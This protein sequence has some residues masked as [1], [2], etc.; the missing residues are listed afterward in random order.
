MSETPPEPQPL[1]VVTSQKPVRSRT[2]LRVT[3]ALVGALA[4]AFSVG[5]F[6]ASRDAIEGTDN[7]FVQLECGSPLFP[8]DNAEPHVSL[9]EVTFQEWDFTTDAL[10][11]DCRSEL[12][13]HRTQG[14]ICLTVALIAGIL[15]VVWKPK[16]HDGIDHLAEPSAPT[17]SAATTGEDPAARLAKLD[18]LR[19]L[20]VISDGEHAAQRAAILDS[21]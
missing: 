21:I 7:A 5:Q 2:W 13:T 18:E 10:R 1:A 11:S 17:T 8:D 14:V 19:R 4:L 16:R 6:L 3:L 12:A 15:V 9:G 20:G